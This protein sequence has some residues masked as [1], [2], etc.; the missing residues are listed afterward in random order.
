MSARLQEVVV[1]LPEPMPEA[2][3]EEL[4]KKLVYVAENVVSSRYDPEARCVR[5]GL[6]DGGVDPDVVAARVREIADKL[7]ALGRLASPRVLARG[8]GPASSPLEDPHPALE[9]S[10]ELIRFGAGRYGLGPLLTRLVKALDRLMEGMAGAMEAPPYQFPS[11]IAAEALDR[12]RYLANFPASLNLVSHLREDLAVLQQFAANVAW[13]DGALQ[14]PATAASPV[15]CLLSPSV[16]FHWYNWLRDSTLERSRSITAVGK[17]FR[18]EAS[19]LAGLERL[20]DF[21]MREI[22]F[23][24]G[25]RFVLDRREDSLAAAT[26]LL[27][28][29]EL[30]YEI[31]TATD[32]FFV[33]TYAV[34]A[35]FQQGFELKFE[36]LCTLPYNAKK[37]AVGSINYHRDFF[38]RSFSIT[39]DGA[40]AHTGCIG[41]G[42][43]RLAL[44]IVAQHGP[45]LSR[46]PA[47]IRD[48]LGDTGSTR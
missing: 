27:D 33:D 4:Q 8:R 1:A 15:D 43:E 3:F 18:Y 12:C 30:Q 7:T 11:L 14:Y 22:V 32:P 25:D 40:P 35:A 10:G 38:G 21:S 34:Q 36:L 19:S 26:R 2:L 39:A 46:W 16:C 24:G 9:A 23:V 17:C 37:L 47:A 31:A 28:A 42:L 48:L 41:F 45:A 13:R 44:A 5:L 6:R 29:L 20:W